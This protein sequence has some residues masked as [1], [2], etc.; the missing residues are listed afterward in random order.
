MKNPPHTYLQKLRSYLDPAVTRKVSGPRRPSDPS[1]RSADPL[2]LS[3]RLMGNIARR[4]DG[5][6]GKLCYET[7]K[8]ESCLRRISG[9]LGTFHWQGRALRRPSCGEKRSGNEGSAR[10]R[11][12]ERR[13][14]VTRN[15]ALEKL[16]GDSA[17]SPRPMMSRTGCDLSQLEAWMRRQAANPFCAFARAAWGEGAGVFVI[18][19]LTAARCQNSNKLMHNSVCVTQGKV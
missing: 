12:R 14:R 1:P 2:S 3:F 6:H 8:A 10:C 11:A 19:K 4:L 5:R 13:G 18:N 16:A 15:Q 7:A 9:R 17:S